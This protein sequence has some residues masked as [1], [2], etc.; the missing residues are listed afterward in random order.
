MPHRSAGRGSAGREDRI[1]QRAQRT[2][3][4]AAGTA[5]LAD[6][7]DIDRAQLSHAD[8]EIEVLIDASDVRLQKALQ[9]V[10]AQ[11]GNIQ[12]ADARNVD[13]AVAVDPGVD[14]QIDLPPGANQQLVSRAD[15][16][17][18]SDGSMVDRGKRRGR[19]F[20]QVRAVDRQ[21]LAERGRDHLLKIGQLDRS[22]LGLVSERELILLPL[23]LGAFGCCGGR[24]RESSRTTVGMEGVTPSGGLLRVRT[25][26]WAAGSAASAAP[27]DTGRRATACSRWY[28][29]A[30]G[31]AHGDSCSRRT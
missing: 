21:R 29:V 6:D 11:S 27:V 20:E 15:N 1:G 25:R 2:D 7:E 4:V 13:R 24:L 17:I 19:L 16:V 14:I 12:T 22:G 3:G 31:A 28:T 30:C 5:R 23:L 10:V 9:L 8:V 18:G 26:L